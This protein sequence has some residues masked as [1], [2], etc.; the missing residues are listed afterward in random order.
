MP[1]KIRNCLLKSGEGLRC[2][3]VPQNAAPIDGDNA[4]DLEFSSPVQLMDLG[5]ARL[6][7]PE[8]QRAEREL[9]R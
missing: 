4:G 7:Q 3:G 5:N 8:W 1:F 2:I 9:E 6:A